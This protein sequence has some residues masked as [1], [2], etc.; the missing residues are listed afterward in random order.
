LRILLDT[1]VFLWLCEDSREL[2]V[3]ARHMIMTAA[4][5]YLSSVSAWGIAVKHR[6]G[7][8]QS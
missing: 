7:A 4:E 1:C 8:C 6:L 3:T 2:S 5:L